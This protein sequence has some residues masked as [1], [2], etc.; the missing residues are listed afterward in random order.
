[1]KTLVLFAVLVALLCSAPARAQELALELAPA[2]PVEGVSAPLLPVPLGLM[3]NE[4]G[5]IVALVEASEEPLIDTEVADA[6][7]AFL[8]REAASRAAQVARALADHIAELA[9]A[10]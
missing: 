2:A 9:A 5:A 6:A 3:R 1:M 10:E 8:A 7:A 4:A